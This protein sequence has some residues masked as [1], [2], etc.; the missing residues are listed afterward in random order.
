[1]NIESKQNFVTR[2]IKF[3]EHIFPLHSLKSQQ[4]STSPPTYMPNA[5]GEDLNVLTGRITT[6]IVID[7]PPVVDEV[8]NAN[9]HN[10]QE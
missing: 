8:L 2:D 3:F 5:C 9:N 4:S 7:S 6:P 1:M 10:E